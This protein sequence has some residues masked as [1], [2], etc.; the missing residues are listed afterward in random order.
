MCR[1]CCTLQDVVESYVNKAV[2][3][4]SNALSLIA[5][6]M[7]RLPDISMHIPALQCLTNLNLSRNN[8]FNGDQL[9][10][11]MLSPSHYYTRIHFISRVH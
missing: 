7:K 11:V 4:Q 10:Q 8:L 2:E 1:M 6:K 3:K 9:F 5:M